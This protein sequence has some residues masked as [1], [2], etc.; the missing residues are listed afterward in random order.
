LLPNASSPGDVAGAVVV[1]TTIAGATGA[2]SAM[3][4][5]M[6]SHFRE[7]GE[8]VF[9]L[10]S[11]MNGALAGL[12]GITAGCGFVEPWAGIVIGGIAGII[13]IASSNLLLRLR[14]DDAVN[15]IPVHFFCGSWGLLAVGFFASPGRLQAAMGSSSH[16]GLFYS[17]GNGGANG[18]LLL[19]QFLAFLFILGW[20]LV[21]MLPFFWLMNG[22]GWLRVDM[23]EEIAGLDAS[24]KHATQ[25]DHEELKEKIL[26]EYRAH[27]DSS[28]ESATRTSNQL[29]RISTQSCSRNRY[30]STGSQHSVEGEDITDTEA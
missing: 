22:L 15:G 7:T 8:F 1:T 5:H 27:K 18:T 12:V 20:T 24:Y 10:T 6:W 23:V 28:A 14:I 26:E 9:D 2:V 30:A 19:C 11:S 17:F 16:V 13:Y 4:I 21:L 25:E 3:A 29:G